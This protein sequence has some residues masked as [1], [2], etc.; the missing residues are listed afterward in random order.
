MPEPEAG[1]RAREGRLSVESDGAADAPP[2]DAPPADA[3]EEELARPRHP[4]RG[5]RTASSSTAATPGLEETT[6]L[7][8]CAICSGVKPLAEVKFGSAL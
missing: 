3:P 2:A 6:S 8:P 7:S 4:A 1:T 5:L